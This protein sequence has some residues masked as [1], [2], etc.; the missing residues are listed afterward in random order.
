MS[1]ETAREN[2][3]IRM[4]VDNTPENQTKVLVVVDP[5]QR[6]CPKC[7]EESFRSDIRQFGRCLDC[8]TAILGERPIVLREM[9][10]VEPQIP[11]VWCG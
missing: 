3:P 6:Q 9:F 5:T 7:G 8:A 2:T 4:A 11:E 10:R 1:T